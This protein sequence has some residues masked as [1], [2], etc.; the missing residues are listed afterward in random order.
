[1]QNPLD[2]FKPHYFLQIPVILLRLFNAFAM[3]YSSCEQYSNGENI[4]LLKE[5]ED[6]RKFVSIAS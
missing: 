6:S 5:I 2:M 1:M 4:L 3:N